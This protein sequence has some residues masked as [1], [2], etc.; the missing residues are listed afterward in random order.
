MKRLFTL[1]VCKLRLMAW[2]L[3]EESFQEQEEVP[4]EVPY[5]GEEVAW[6]V[7]YLGRLY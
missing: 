1:D 2:E 7:D 5:P 3:E 6:P 4:E